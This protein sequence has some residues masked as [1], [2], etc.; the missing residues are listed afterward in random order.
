MATTT[1]G[2]KL[3]ATVSGADQVKKLK[4]EIKAAEAEA[5]KISKEFGASSVEAQKA[6]EQVTKLAQGLNSFKSIK[7]QIR[8]A[9]QEAFAM[10][11][12]FGEFSTEALAAAKRVAGLKDTM[13]DF[14]QRVQALNPDKFEA[15]GKLVGG[16][17]SGVSAAQGA[18]ALFGGESEELQKALLKVQGAMALSQG[19]NGVI[20][21]RKQF[22][23]FGKDAIS[24]FKGMTTA[25]KAFLA[26]GIGL[27][28]TAIAYVATNFDEL[29][30]S[31]GFAE[32]EMQKMNKAMNMAAAETKQQAADL[33]YY[34]SIVQDTKK[35]EGEREF[36]LQKL[37]E[38]GVATDDV[39]I[40]NANSLGALND[41]IAKQILL[42]AQRARTEAAAQILQEKTK[43]LLEMQ[44]GDLDK[45]T[46]FWDNFYASAKGALLGVD[47]GA[48]E[49]VDRGLNNLKKGQQDVN[50]ATK[51]YQGELQKNTKLNGEHN[52]I[53][54]QVTSTLKKQKDAT[55]DLK[56]AELE[57]IAEVLSLD[58]STLAKQIAAADAAFA[59]TVKALREKGLTEKQ[60]NQ[61]R[62]A[63]LEKI[64]TDFYAK[65]KA[66]EE[67][68]ATDLAAWKKQKDEEELTGLNEFYKKKQ[69]VAIQ[70]NATPE[71]LA[72]LELQRMDEEKRL[73][74]EQGQSII[75]IE[76]QIAAKKK[77]IYD[78]DV[79]DKKKAEEQK[80][81]AEQ[82][83]LK[84]TA[85]GFAII[86]EMADAF[87]GKSEQ[88]QRKA[89][90]I[91]KK[92]SIAQAI[93]ETIQAS[94]SAYASQMAIATPDAPIR[95][96]IAAGLALASGI[97]RVR[98][99]EQTP[100]E[101]KGDSAGGG[102]GGG[103]GV[104]PAPSFTPTAG[105]ALP[106]EA[107]FGGMGRVYVLEGDITKTQTRVR[108]L[109]NTSVV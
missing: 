23:D 40:A 57:R 19:I 11:Q 37:K 41:R 101:A 83:T 13:Q 26:T 84:F 107:Q 106:E 14:Q 70:N 1:V 22:V 21:A 97:A 89:F 103:G 27:L 81:A 58:K 10:S 86:A 43:K 88:Q 91:K 63:E 108:R 100:F 93:I 34:N 102:G 46:T 78:K 94:Q 90:E 36:A 9:T 52:T 59:V 12:K 17:A 16:L 7:T 50:D 30:Q 99:I 33:Q 29:A 42:I 67:K 28:V 62:D 15:I 3:D 75:D 66:D 39:N 49:L 5:K 82:A 51:V 109:R 32:S 80:K 24:A 92:A 87:A 60:I 54:Q 44:N 65:Q 61:K 48:Q 71:Q 68:A 85:D 74:L 35:S 45:A 76:L 105:G 8:E 73:R 18:M 20:E 95:A 77:E 64:R 69:S 47:R 31:M 2:I 96:A 55:K 4:A 104:A 72:A 53:S 25:S 6:A 38:A 98:K 56:Q 79:E